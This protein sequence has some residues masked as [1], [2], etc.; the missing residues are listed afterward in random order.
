MSAPQM[1]SH[2]IESM[3]MATG[4]LPVAPKPGPFRYPPLKQLIIYYLPWPK[5][6]PTAPELLTRSPH[7][8]DTDVK[9]LATLLDRFST[10]AVSGPWPEHP[11][12]G[13][14]SGDAWGFLAHRHVDHHLRQFG[15]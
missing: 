12:F 4:E 1:V 6:A 14:L 11:A 7:Q 9:E 8:W 10:R 13:P 15:V 5:D 3:R 2:L